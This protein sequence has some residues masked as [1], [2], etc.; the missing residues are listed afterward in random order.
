[1]ANTT[2]RD[3]GDDRIRDVPSGH[4]ALGFP[5][6]RYRLPRYHDRLAGTRVHLLTR[7]KSIEHVNWE[8]LLGDVLVLKVDDRVQP[9]SDLGLPATIMVFAIKKE[10]ALRLNAAMDYGELRVVVPERME[11]FESPKPK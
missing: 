1:M 7:E 6:P 11:N 9:E 2:T 4:I 8:L 10:D 5:V 3:R